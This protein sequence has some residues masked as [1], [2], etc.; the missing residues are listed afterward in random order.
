M[1]GVKRLLRSGR[2]V[3]TMPDR[4]AGRDQRFHEAC[5][6][7]ERSTSLSARQKRNALERLANRYLDGKDDDVKQGGVLGTHRVDPG[8]AAVI[9]DRGRVRKGVHG[10]GTHVGV[11]GVT[12]VE[13]FDVRVQRYDV[14][15]HVLTKRR[16]PFEID[17]HVLHRIESEQVLGMF[18]NVG[19]DYDRKLIEPFLVQTARAVAYTRTEEE[20]MDPAFGETLTQALLASLEG[21]GLN[22]MITVKDVRPADAVTEAYAELARAEYEQLRIGADIKVFELR[23]KLRIMEFALESGF[24]IAEADLEATMKEIATRVQIDLDAMRT[25]EVGQ[26]ETEV[27]RERRQ[28]DYFSEAYFRDRIIAAGGAAMGV[29]AAKDIARILAEGFADWLGKK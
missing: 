11:P 6:R 7:I 9:H 21:S 1:G 5:E 18:D 13:Q 4:R 17:V 19:R 14:T 29:D 23:S 28:A 16:L 25:R 3:A 8:H 27:E 24:R 12:K 2:E 10:P 15:L 26:A 20:M 22:V